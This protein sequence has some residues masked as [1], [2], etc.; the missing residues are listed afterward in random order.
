MKNL[1]NAQKI[2]FATIVPL[3]LLV[4]ALAIM[5]DISSWNDFEDVWLVWVI[6]L[7]VVLWLELKLFSSN[8]TKLF[9][10]SKFDVKKY[11]IRIFWVSLILFFVFSVLFVLL[12]GRHVRI[13]PA[14]RYLF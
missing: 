9:D 2:I 13:L 7:I 8:N 10:L 14:A 5:D 1:S 11:I 3:I 4:I 12:A 6:L